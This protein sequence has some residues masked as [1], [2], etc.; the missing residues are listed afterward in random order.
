MELRQK[1][2]GQKTMF[3]QLDVRENLLSPAINQSFFSFVRQ[4][5]VLNLIVVAKNVT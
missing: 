1:T 4:S 3:M 2:I 5:F